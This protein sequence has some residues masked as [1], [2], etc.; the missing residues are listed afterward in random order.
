[1]KI[2]D[3]VHGNLYVVVNPF[4]NDPL[5]AMCV[6]SAFMVEVERGAGTQLV[7]GNACTFI[8]VGKTK[9]DLS[10]EIISEDEAGCYISNG[11]CKKYLKPQGIN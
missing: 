8:P 2:R 10:K 6:K 9:M 4:T 7:I 1:M 11:K 3:L 5:V